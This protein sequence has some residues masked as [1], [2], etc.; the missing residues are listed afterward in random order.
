MQSINQDERYKLRTHHRLAQ[1][2]EF[3]DDVSDEDHECGDD[4]S[5]AIA[6]L[7]EKKNKAQD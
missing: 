5:D 7:T 4:E 1:F 3:H 2:K 6:F